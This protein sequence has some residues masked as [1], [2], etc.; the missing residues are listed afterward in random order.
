MSELEYHSPPT[1]TPAFE[2]PSAMYYVRGFI[3]WIASGV[4]SSFD[5]RWGALAGLLTGLLLL[6]QDR[7]RG[8]PTDSEV[9]EIS[10][11]GYFAVMGLLAL[12]APHGVRDT[13]STW[14][15]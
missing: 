1:A 15:D 12:A 2:R 14:D 13:L 10:S 5:L 7:R 8:V 3:P 9:L 11:I 6:L 4:I